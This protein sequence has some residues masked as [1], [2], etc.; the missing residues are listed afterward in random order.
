[1]AKYYTL[2]ETQEKLGLTEDRV[3]QLIQ[4]GQLSQYRDSGKVV[5]PREEV[6]ALATKNDTSEITL[7]PVDEDEGDSVAGLTGA[8]VISLE[9]VEELGS[10][11]GTAAGA[12]DETVITSVGISVFGEEDV[13]APA[14]DP[15][16]KTHIQDDTGE[17]ALESLGSSGSGLLDL[18]RESDDTSLGAEL[19]DEIYPEEDET[20]EEEPIVA[21]EEEETAIPTYSPEPTSPVA[22]APAGV[23]S[24]DPL[25]PLFTGLVV[26]SVLLVGL[27]GVVSAAAIQGVWPGFLK[28]LS[29][30][31]LFFLGGAAVAGLVG[32]GIG[33]ASGRRG[34]GPAVARIRTVE[35]DLPDEPEA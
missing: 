11:G 13:E 7:E 26:V 6:D 17:I 1:M 30:Q 24:A 19:L 35:S 5:V 29:S 33:W 18:S 32:A 3:R 4:S 2:E 21:A 15:M 28:T 22:M 14:V 25:A 8:D 34:S 23:A 20:L 27:V 12:K 16:A 10:K 9:E 31:P